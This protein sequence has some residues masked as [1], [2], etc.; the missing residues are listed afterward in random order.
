[1]M[2]ALRRLRLGRTQQLR[3]ATRFAHNVRG[4]AAVEFAMLAPILLLLLIGVYEGSRAIGLDRRFSLVTSMAGDLVSREQDMG[5][6]PATT[7]R[8][9]MNVIDHV[10]G[11]GQGGSLE[12]EVIPVM[13]FGQDGKDT[14]T[15]APSYKRAKDGTISVSKAR[16]TRYEL[17]PGIVGLGDSVIVVVSTYQYTPDALGKSL[18]PPMEWHEKSTHSPRHGCVDFEDNNCSVT[19]R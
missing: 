8:G 17:P 11:E 3:G 2:R 9:I 18:F 19:C 4:V 1:M 5:A 12:M 14:R 10:M 6:N 16:C 15:Y 7:I 13:G